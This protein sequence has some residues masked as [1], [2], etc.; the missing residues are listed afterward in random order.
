MES[1]T[2]CEH[3][4]AHKA[5]RLGVVGR[6]VPV[7]VVD[8]D[9]VA[10]PLVVTDRWLDPW[11]RIVLGEPKTGEELAAGK[12]L[13][14]RAKTDLSLLDKEVESICGRFA[15]TMPEC[16]TRTVESVR[17]HKLQYWYAN[18]EESRAWL[19][20]NMATEARAGFRAFHEGDRDRREVDFARLRRSMAEGK[21]WDDSLLAD[22]LENR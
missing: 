16:L 19:A 5:Y 2:L 9:F 4:S 15:Q 18:A 11:G 1:A 8:G 10:N 6:I 14:A 7:L 21:A 20:L 22:L 12:A 13:L 3:W 17:K